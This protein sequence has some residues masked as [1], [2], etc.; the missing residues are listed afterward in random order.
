MSW[1]ITTFPS[2]L[3]LI[4]TQ[5]NLF[6]LFLGFEKPIHLWDHHHH[7]R[8]AVCLNPSSG[9]LLQPPH[10][11]SLW[12]SRITV[13]PVASPVPRKSTLAISAAVLWARSRWCRG[14]RD[15]SVRG[16]WLLRCS[17][18]YHR[19]HRRPTIL[20]FICSQVARVCQRQR[21][22]EGGG[23]MHGRGTASLLS[24]WCRWRGTRAGGGHSR[25]PPP[26]WR[27]GAEQ[28]YCSG[29]ALRAG[30]MAPLIGQLSPRLRCTPSYERAGKSP[31]RLRLFLVVASACKFQ[32]IETVHWWRFRCCMLDCDGLHFPLL[33]WGP[34]T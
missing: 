26:A 14:F 29:M 10:R 4:K 23:S 31:V 2:L 34:W 20:D 5:V 24:L 22:R 8:F 33:N 6:I 17:H 19:R 25:R 21:A 3:T 30:Q 18:R 1:P 28:G 7:E 27:R 11:L 12:V 16:T 32:T 15:L 13:A 9:L